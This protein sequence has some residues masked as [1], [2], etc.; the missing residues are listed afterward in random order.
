MFQRTVFALAMLAS[1]GWGSAMSSV[2]FAETEAERQACTPDAQTH[3]FDE[4]PDRDRVYQCL[5][6][7]VNILSPACKKVISESIAASRR[8][9]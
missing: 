7:K 8:K 3:C 6:Q 5:V 1:V 9:K 2:A 4:I